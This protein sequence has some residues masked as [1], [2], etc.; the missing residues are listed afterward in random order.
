MNRRLLVAVACGL[1][2]TN[3]AVLASTKYSAPGAF[4]LIPLALLLA[5]G[6]GGPLFVTPAFRA[7]LMYGAVVAVAALVAVDSASALNSLT[8]LLVEALLLWL[9]VL[10]AVRDANLLRAAVAGLIV[11]AALLA[12]LSVAQYVTADYGNEY[13]G[14]AQLEDGGLLRKGK[15]GGNSLA[16]RLRPARNRTTKC[17]G[18]CRCPLS[19]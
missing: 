13:F 7:L 17:R 12:T 15:L 5:A 1:L 9:L 18:L 10:Y 3:I 11:A 2:W 4:G 14:L 8:T 6:V 19:V 16:C